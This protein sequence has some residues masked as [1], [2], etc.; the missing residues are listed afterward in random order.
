M[1][2][3]KSKWFVI[4]QHEG[5]QSKADLD[6]LEPYGDL[7]IHSYEKCYRASAVY[8]LSVLLCKQYECDLL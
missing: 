3:E 5:K 4:L 6:I 1:E 7:L 8:S 2:E